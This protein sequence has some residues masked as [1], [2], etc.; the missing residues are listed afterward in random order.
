MQEPADQHRAEAEPVEAE[1]VDV[2]AQERQHQQRHCDQHQQEPP[3]LANRVRGVASVFRR[4]I[5]IESSA[6]TLP[7]GG[8]QDTRIVTPAKW[9]QRYAHVLMGT[10]KS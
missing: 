10:E 9:I 4:T 8:S 3:T 6:P 1:G 2:A 7:Y 5:T